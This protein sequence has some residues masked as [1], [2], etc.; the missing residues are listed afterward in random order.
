MGFKRRMGTV[1]AGIALS[2]LAAGGISLS[3]YAQDG[4]TV[5][6]VSAILETQGAYAWD[7]ERG[8]R[9]EW[10][11]EPRAD[12]DLGGLGTFTGIARLEIDGYD[13]LEPGRPGQTERSSGN[14]RILVGDRAGVEL[15]EAYLT[16]SAG[17]ITYRLGKQQVVWGEADGLKVLD[18]VN[19]QSFRA[20]I[21]DD[22]DVSRIPLWTVNLETRIAGI[23]VQAV[24][25]PDRTYHE[26]PEPG[27]TFALTSP[28]FTPP[29]FALDR[30]AV[31]RIERPDNG[32]VR[33]SDAGIRLS[34]FWGGWDLSALYLYHYEDRPVFEIT[35]LAE[36]TE[37][38]QIYD[39]VH[40]AGVTASNAFGDFVLRTEIGFT[41]GRAYNV[42]LDIAPDG[43]AESDNLSYVLGLDYY[44]L[45]KGV[46][47]A[48]LFQDVVLDDPGGLPRSRVDSFATLTWRGRF[49]NDRLRPE[50]QWL[51]NLN[52]GDGL[53]R[54]S[55][56]YELSDALT[57][58]IG[59]DL[60]YGDPLG[61]FGE[62]DRADRITAGFKLGI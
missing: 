33:D 26:L 31:F 2:A 28:R 47:S 1:S 43:I 61:V 35:R 48:Q 44:G 32:P 9:L 58:T 27:A 59:G 46:I 50:V 18:V 57:V 20:F 22:F 3:A 56:A 13:R 8:D 54:V 34:A 60:F 21:L 30:P 40:L 39:R 37:I 49:S 36:R 42:T 51:S 62:F 55:L 25:I 53:V 11:F 16:G 10:R 23:D 41:W 17:P 7:E 19:P 6:D 14:R 4:I 45:P 12:M 15:R 38:A 5:T 52:D 24:W 29:P